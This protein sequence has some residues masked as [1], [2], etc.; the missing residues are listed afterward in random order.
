[1]CYVL[2]ILMI[3]CLCSCKSDEK[4]VMEEIPETLQLSVEI[5]EDY[6]KTATTYSADFFFV[7]E[8][9]AKSA[10][11][12]ENS[13]TRIEYAEGPQ[14]V[15]EKE[16]GLKYFISLYNGSEKYGS[17][18]MGGLLYSISSAEDECLENSSYRHRVNSCLRKK[19]FWE[20]VSGNLIN[21]GLNEYQQEEDLSIGTLSD[22]L[23]DVEKKMEICDFPEVQ[24]HTIDSCSAEIIN[25]NRKIFNAALQ[26]GSE[27]KP[28]LTE[29]MPDSEYYFITYR[30]VLDE[31]PLSVMYWSDS[32]TVAK[33]EISLFY[34]KSGLLEMA[35]RGLYAVGDPISTSP[36]ISPEN[37][38]DI[39]LKQYNKSIHF[40]ISE[41]INFELDYVKIVNKDGMRLRP[42]WIISTRTLQSESDTTNAQNIYANYAVSADSGILLETEVDT[43]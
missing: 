9:K 33:T 11:G 16:F 38:L 36:V 35:A 3:L 30:Q 19:H 1:M 29:F 5:P 22:V 28:F 17:S 15:C 34:G 23:K 10:F 13:F 4:Y 24:L 42:A 40:E 43:R 12:N 2:S 31:I 27:E 37:A 41:I 7:D 14:F 25:R 21:E 6:P 20:S 32:N 39:F 18:A 8:E 26:G